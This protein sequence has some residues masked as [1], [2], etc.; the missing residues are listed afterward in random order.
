LE[1]KE[2]RSLDAGSGNFPRGDVNL[3]LFR[4]NTPHLIHDAS[5]K[6]KL[7]SRAF[8]R[9]DCMHLPFRDNIFDESFCSHVLE[10]KGINVRKTLEELRRVTNYTIIIVVPHHRSRIYNKTS[11]HVRHFNRS[12][13]S[14]FLSSMGFIFRFKTTYESLLHPYL[15]FITIPSEIFVEI[16]L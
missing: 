7:K 2:Y 16:Q 5:V 3:D 1:L 8:I 13:L 4:N 15:S 6:T 11:C 12:N 10:H 9:G 14:N